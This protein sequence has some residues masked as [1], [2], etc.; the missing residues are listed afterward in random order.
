MVGL[1]TASGE[2][3][4]KNRRVIVQTSFACGVGISVV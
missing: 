4:S 2:G 1:I 3:L